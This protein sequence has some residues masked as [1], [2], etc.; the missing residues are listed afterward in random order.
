MGG[1]VATEN[2]TRPV[3]MRGAY[4]CGAY[5]SQDRERIEALLPLR[6]VEFHVLLS[7][8]SGERHGYGILQDIAERDDASVPDVGTMYRALARMVDS[9][10]IKASSS[11]EPGDERRSK[12]C[13]AER[14]LRVAKA[15][16]RRLQAL[17]R[18]V[19]ANPHSRLRSPPEGAGTM[20]SRLF[21]GVLVLALITVPLRVAA[22]S[23]AVVA[24]WEALVRVPLPP[25]G[26]P[27]IS[28]NALTMP[29]QPVAEHSHPGQTIGYIA[30]GEIENQVAP[31]APAVYKPGSHF[32]EAPRQLHKMMRN[33][34]AEPAKLLIFHA[35]RTG[36][37]APLLKPLQGDTKLTFSENTQWQV[38]LPSTANQEL[39]LIRL[40][41]PVG[42][43]T[44]VAAH[45]GPGMIYVL[46]GSISIV[47]TGVPQPLT[48]NAGDLFPDP[49]KRDGVIFRNLTGKGPATLLLYH[50]S[51]PQSLVQVPPMMP[52][53]A[54]DA[55]KFVRASQATF[56]QDDDFV[57]GVARGA[58]VKAY[59][60][61]LLTQTGSVDDQMPDGP[62][63]VTW[64]STCG[65]GAVFRAEI[66]GRRLHFQYDSMVNANEVHKDVETGSRW[67]QST[68]EAISGPLKGRTLTLYPFILT[69][70]KAWRTRYPNTEILQP[71]PGYAA[72]IPI[73][74]PRQRQN[75]RSGEGPAP[76]G[77]FGKDDRLRPREMI[78]GLAVGTETMAFPLSA[79]RTSPVVNERV[80]GVPVVVIH[81]PSSDTTTAFEAS[82]KG[83]ALRFRAANADATSLT[84]LETGSIWDPYGL[85]LKGPLKGT[86][87]KSLILIPEFWFAW[88]QFRPGTRLYTG[89]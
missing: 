15:E 49:A 7:L 61:L 11:S 34:S 3:G 76:D 12:N 2:L 32:Y 28:V 29:A 30:Q 86:Q 74:R 84:D 33:V 4:M 31:D 56:A 72:R 14:G 69:T 73:L 22:Q 60:A 79:L 59:Q 48:Y 6:P 55:P 68:G 64:C 44:E 37:P 24:R 65:T 17:T 20:T 87:L 21:V 10:L 23:A 40:T 82:V 85:C 38:P 27:V 41:M 19:R 67:Q 83:R 71:E 52:Y 54:I 53:V 39:R 78:A 81:Q 25:D 9:G 47:G 42:S 77:A 8:A 50:V 89:R 46:E 26:D 80:G 45:S 70:W 18:A 1:G 58:T 13:I 57:I 75:L 88:S 63:E 62:I 43:R 5:M 51:D 36:V 66:D 35:G 16:A